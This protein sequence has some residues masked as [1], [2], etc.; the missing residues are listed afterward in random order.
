MMDVSVGN[1]K[2]EERNAVVVPSGRYF[3]MVERAAQW[4]HKEKGSHWLILDLAVKDAQGSKHPITL[5]IC[6]MRADGTK[7][8]YGCNE[9]ASIVAACGL[10]PAAFEEADLKGRKC[11]VTLDHVQEGTYP[12]KNQVIDAEVVEPGVNV[13]QAGNL[14]PATKPAPAATAPPRRP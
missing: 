10:D 9:I 12:P 14:I 11:V 13:D 4:T 8:Q 1:G 6:W 7:V 5:F 2:F 3:A